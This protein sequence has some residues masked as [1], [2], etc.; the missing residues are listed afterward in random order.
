MN[1]NYIIINREAALSILNAAEKRCSAR[2][3]GD[4]EAIEA[5]LKDLLAEKGYAKTCNSKLKGIRAIMGE[6]TGESRS[7][8]KYFNN[9]QTTWAVL[10]HNGKGWVLESACRDYTSD[11]SK[12]L[13]VEAS[14]AFEKKRKARESEVLAW[15]EE[16]RQV[17]DSILSAIR[18]LTKEDVECIQYVT[19][20]AVIKMTVEKVG[21]ELGKD[22]R[23]HFSKV[24][25]D[26]SF[27]E[28]CFYS[29]SIDCGRVLLSTKVQLPDTLF[30]ENCENCKNCFFCKDCKD[31][32][33]CIK[34]TGCTDCY[35]CENCTNCS[36]DCKECTA[37]N[38]CK[39]CH[40]CW[41]S[42][43]CTN[44]YDCG[45]CED[46]TNCEYCRSCKNKRGCRIA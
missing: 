25:N 46:C 20:E 35:R 32:E 16:M 30:C 9:N 18:S 21:K 33:Y 17:N 5:A 13:D 24:I 44:C 26:Y 36:D 28:V 15:E 34:C 7:R 8:G 42:N 4:L 11:D 37:C 3:F 45:G 10:A 41:S 31:C 22:L 39:V 19:I 27:I 12:I 40:E 1:A 23:V 2:T 14:K 38:G 43:N 29:K 6:T